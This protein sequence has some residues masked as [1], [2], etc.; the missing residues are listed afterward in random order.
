MD[1]IDTKE[2]MG[3]EESI[4]KMIKKNRENLEKKTKKKGHSKDNNQTRKSKSKSIEKKSRL[5]EKIAEMLEKLSILMQKKGD[6]MRARVYSRA[7]DT[8]LLETGDIADI[9]EL[10]GKSGIGPTI[11]VKMNEYISTGKL[12]VLEKEKENPLIWLTEIHGIGP[13]KATELIEKG[14]YKMEDLE[15]RKDELLNNVQKKG[16]QYYEEINQRIPRDEID[17]Y[18]KILESSFKKVADGESKQEIVGSFRRGSRTSGDIDVII[19]SKNEDIFKNY[20]EE[21]KE[22]GIIIEVL[23]NGKTKS[24]VIARLNKESIARRV[25]FMYTPQEE[26]PFAILYFTGSKIFNTV[27]RGHALNQGL[28]LNEHGIYKKEK[29][30]EKGERISKNFETEED[31][32]EY[33]DL[34]YKKPEERIDGRAVETTIPII[35]DEEKINVEKKERKPRI[36]KEKNKGSPKRKYVKKPKIIIEENEKVEAVPIIE[37]EELPEL[38]PIIAINIPEPKK[39]SPKNKT[40]K[41]TL[42][43]NDNINKEKMPKTKTKK[44][45]STELELG[46]VSILEFKEQGIMVLEGMGEKGLEEMIEL[47]NHQYYNTKNPLLTDVEYDIIVEYMERKYPNNLVLQGVG[48]KV[49]KN[50]VRLPYEMASMDKIKPDTNALITWKSKYSGQYVLSCKLDGVSGLYTTE[51]GEAKL[52]TRGDGK[53]GQDITHLLKVLKLPKHEG[54][55]V[56][57]EFIILKEVFEEKYSKTFAN[58]RNLVSGIVNSK[59]IDEKAR[60]LHFVAYEVIKPEMKPSEQM[61]KLIELEHEV[62]KHQIEEEITNEQLSEILIDWRTNHE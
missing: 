37:K 13:K 18:K 2:V 36:L 30:K 47:A 11:M 49:E 20:M 33:L 19:T 16:L 46:K 29:G 48:A 3:E 9:K 12:S 54:H 4:Q 28:S 59:T 51:N 32:F 15:G 14:I 5:N 10:E 24:M 61:N 55:V 60:D 1:I 27:M 44:N 38:V 50:K 22:K 31:I 17:E 57:G 43:K 53:V 52:Y 39:V 35:K 34:K 7:L 23:S 41:I 58:P 21:L 8:V 25:D 62:V 56:R 26:Y 45:K 6:V 42:K 40:K